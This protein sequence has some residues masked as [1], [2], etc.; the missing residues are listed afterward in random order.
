MVAVGAR[1]AAV[2]G[3]E[4]SRGQVISYLEVIKRVVRVHVAEQVDQIEAI[5]HVPGE[6][7]S[8]GQDAADEQAEQRVAQ[9][10]GQ[11]YPPPRPAQSCPQNGRPRRAGGYFAQRRSARPYCSP[12]LTIRAAARARRRTW[13]ATLSGSAAGNGGRSIPA[14]MRVHTKPGS[15]VTTW[16]PDGPPAPF[17]PRRSRRRLPV[18]RRLDNI[19]LG[20]PEVMETAFHGHVLAG[21]DAGNSILRERDSGH[22]P[23]VEY[24]AALDEIEVQVVKAVLLAPVGKVVPVNRVQGEKE[25]RRR[26]GRG[27]RLLDVDKTVLDEI[28]IPVGADDRAGCLRPVLPGN[29]GRAPASLVRQNGR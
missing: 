14:V 27:A 23:P 12:Y 9:P 11:H 19:E 18:I 15:I 25:P 20:F 22:T 26:V 17:R 24:L 2:E 3:R 10:G 6:A 1:D 16:T 21:G 28:H 7:G 5:E 4:V 8:V 13:A 29:R